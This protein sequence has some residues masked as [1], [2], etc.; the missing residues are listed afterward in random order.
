M[1]NADIIKSALSEIAAKNG[2]ILTPDAVVQ[3][4]KQLES[5]LHDC[6]E[7]DNKKAAHQHRLDQARGLIRSVKLEIVR[8]EKV[9][10]SVYWVRDPEQPPEQQGYKSVINLHSEET[11]ARLALIEEFKR[12]D[13]MLERARN[14]AVVLSLEGDIDDLRES[15]KRVSS[16]VQEDS[17]LAS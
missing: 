3:E 10:T 17:L 4:A 8:N 14:L 11:A 2:G 7:W 6:F 5:P 1:T 13:A 15:F 16:K 12:A 9:I